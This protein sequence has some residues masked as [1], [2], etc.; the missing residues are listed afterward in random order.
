MKYVLL[1][2]LL[3]A[4]LAASAATGPVPLGPDGGAFGDWTAAK[5]KTGA[6]KVCYA[7]TNA[8]SSKPSLAGRSNVLLTVTERKASHDEVTLTAG[9]TYPANA[10]VALD[11]KGL[12]VKF[13]TKGGNA[14][15]TDGPNA[16]AA[17]EKTDTAT[18]TSTGPTGATVVDIF[19]LK[20]FTNAF[21][22]VVKACK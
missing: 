20:G 2:G 15:T 4:P 7:F 9:F 17:F 16:V 21:K 6:A 3:L 12:T 1:L 8:Q 19:S 5:Y 11:V 18:V 10:K 14:F 13:Y 22:A